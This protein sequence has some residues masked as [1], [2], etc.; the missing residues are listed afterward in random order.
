MSRHY[1][2]DIATQNIRNLNSFISAT[3]AKIN[4]RGD[5]EDIDSSRYDLHML[6]TLQASL[7]DEDDYFNKRLSD[8]ICRI[9]KDLRENHRND[10]ETNDSDPGKNI[11]NNVNRLINIRN[12]EQ[13]STEPL[14]LTFGLQASKAS[15]NL[16]KDL[17]AYLRKHSP[18]FR[19]TGR[20]GRGPKKNCD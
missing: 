15:T 2:D 14:N 7:I 11:M 16:F 6:R 17:F 13:R 12:P 5:K 19:S 20:K 1:I 8:D 10:P 4:E 9:S 18:L 3:R